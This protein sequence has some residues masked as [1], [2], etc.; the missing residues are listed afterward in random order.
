[1]PTKKYYLNL[2]YQR[3]AKKSEYLNKINKDVIS[4]E[5]C[6]INKNYLEV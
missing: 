6:I 5:S 3:L 2:E 4:Y 1:M